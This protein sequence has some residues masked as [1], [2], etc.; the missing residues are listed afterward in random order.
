MIFSF[1]GKTDLEKSR[2][3]AFE[4]VAT[5]KIPATVT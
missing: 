2:Y 1:S 3:L 4:H 5:V